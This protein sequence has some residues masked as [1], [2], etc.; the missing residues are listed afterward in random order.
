[1]SSIGNMLITG[2]SISYQIFTTFLNFMRSNHSHVIHSDHGFGYE[3]ICGDVVT[4]GGINLAWVWDPFLNP[5]IFLPYVEEW[6]IKTVLVNTGAKYRDDLLYV[7]AVQS[8]I[9]VLQARYPHLLVIFRNTPP[10]NTSPDQG[11]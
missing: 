10:G 5:N 3:H 11:Y 4:G 1:M 8:T 2:D 6:D 7:K 9:D